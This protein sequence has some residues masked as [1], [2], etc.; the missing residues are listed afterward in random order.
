[1]GGFSLPELLILLVIVGILAALAAPL[2][3]SYRIRA[4]QAEATVNLAGIF[5]AERAF[6]GEAERYSHFADIGFWLAGGVNRYTYRTHGT[7]AQGNDTGEVRIPP[8]IGLVT[9]EN[10]LVT[11][12]SSLTG[13]TA[14]ATANLDLDALIDQWHVNDRGDG[15]LRPDI[16]DAGESAP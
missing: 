1:M 5:A 14:T 16:N 4:Y 6:Y 11:S 12:A 3:L 10:T 9:P 2:F 13:F 15:V 8:T 7:T